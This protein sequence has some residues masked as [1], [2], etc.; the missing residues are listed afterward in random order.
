MIYQIVITYIERNKMNF[1]RYLS[2]T[3]LAG[4]LN[5]WLLLVFSIFTQSNLIYAQEIDADPW[6]LMQEIVEAVRPPV[7]SDKEFNILKFG[8]DPTGIHSNTEVFKKAIQACTSAGG[9]RVLVPKGVYI[10]GAIHLDNNVNLHLEEGAEIKF[11]TNPND[12]LP[13]VPTS[14]EGIELINYSPLIYAYQKK[15]IAITGKGTLNGQASIDNWWAWKGSEQYGWSK[16]MPSQLDSLNLPQLMK[17]GENGIS[18]GDRVFG[19]NHYLR[20]NFFE[21]YECENVMLQG[22]KIIKA[23][24]WIIH[25]LKSTNV[26]VDGVNIESHGPNND[27]CDPEYSKNVIIKNSVFNTGDDCIAI[28]AGRDN[29]GRRVAVKSENIVIQNCRMIDGH[30]GVVIGS[31]M[32]S[33]VKNVFVEN[34]VMDSPELDRAIRIKSNSKRGG[35][36]ENIFVRNLE[37]G[38]VKEALLKINLFYATYNN[39]T[40]GFIPEVR[41]I[42]LENIRVAN[43]GQFGLLLIG[44]DGVPIDGITLKNVVIQEVKEPYSLKNVINLKLIDTYMNGKLVGLNSD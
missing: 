33:G 43:S 42:S 34:C 14:F 23:P 29:D 10:T 41:N 25:P 5:Y 6:S 24:F 13:L 11:S 39:Q 36:V 37:V 35:I 32:S 31:E 16:G 3:F 19:P 22:V 15:N 1:N 40:G 18:V 2:K 38:N 27:G 26:I 4:P 9:G 7:F 17:M 44:H 28:K 12:Y 20:P 30:G 8:A 21:P